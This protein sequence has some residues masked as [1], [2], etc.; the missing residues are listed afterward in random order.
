MVAD[1]DGQPLPGATVRVSPLLGTTTDK[2]GLY[3]L[4]VP[5]QAFALT[6]SFIGYTTQTKAFYREDIQNLVGKEFK[7]HFKMEEAIETLPTAN[8]SSRRLKKVYENKRQIIRDFEL[9]GPY[10]LL[11]LQEKRTAFLSLQTE[12][13]EVIDTMH[14]PFK[15]F[16]LHKGCTGAF[17]L[18][19][20][21]EAIEISVEKDKLYHL[22][23]YP[24][25]A[26]EKN[27]LPC[28]AATP[29][30]ILYKRHMDKLNQTSY[31]A[32][33]RYTGHSTVLKEIKDWEKTEAS[34]VY[35]NEIIAD[36]YLHVGSDPFFNV[37]E[38]GRWTGDL[39]DL[40]VNNQLMAKITYYDHIVT[41]AISTAA[42][43][44][45]GNWVIFDHQNDSSFY[46]S[47]ALEKTTTRPL[48]YPTEKGWKEA[49]YQ[50][51]NTQRIYACFEE[52]DQMY[53]KEVNPASGTTGTTF[54]LSN[55]YYFLKEIKIKDGAAYFIAQDAPTSPYRQV[56]K[57]YLVKKGSLQ[58]QP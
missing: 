9:A 18:A 50:D 52:N 57:Q 49:L 37:I 35:L 12:K 38:D 27:I 17:H 2:E 14:L 54:G 20:H 24:V 13:G 44:H 8:V 34:K 47:P 30:F 51:Q 31:F 36:Y 29:D 6:A 41:K 33:N 5:K 21:W 40:A 56:Y 15:A 3:R 46:F 22:K 58:E 55:P 25:E 42:F 16:H 26:F 32:V 28:Q 53:F 43:Q 4:S 48:S 10:L 23:T 39:L 45:E 11:L 19:G 1:Q 7:V